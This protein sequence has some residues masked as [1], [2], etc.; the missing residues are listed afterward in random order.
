MA[1]GKCFTNF[2]WMVSVQKPI[3]P[4]NTLIR[5]LSSLKESP[6]NDEKVT[7]KLPVKDV[8]QERKSLLS[9]FHTD[10][11]L[12]LNMSTLLNSIDL[13]AEGIKK[14][15][16]ERQE[17]ILAV[18]QQYLP[19]RAETLGSDLAAAHFV[20]HR[21]GKVRFRG[22]EKWIE[23]DKE[24]EESSLPKFF[25]ESFAAEALDCSQ[26][27]LTHQGLLNMKALN[28]LQWLSLENCP[29]IDDWCLDRVAGQYYSSLEYLNIRNCSKVTERGI[30]SLSKMNKLKVLEIGGH[31]TTQNLELVCL[32]L[33]DVLPNL[34]V[35]GIT[36]SL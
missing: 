5:S 24:T 22:Q 11:N 2:K 23:L 30:S 13:S 21:G 17:R 15:F 20:V 6:L 1:I 16:A 18:N 8:S 3:T 28:N 27:T 33:E 31:E 36:Y 29:H 10:Y 7:Y 26:M 14:M 35:K 12:A 9:V 25:D 34:T 19:L 32:M 4:L